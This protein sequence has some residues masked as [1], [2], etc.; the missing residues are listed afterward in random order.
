M[1]QEILCPKCEA[2][3]ERKPGPYHPFYGC[4]NYP[5]CK[6]MRKVYP[7]GLVE[8]LRVDRETRDYQHIAEGRFQRLWLSVDDDLNTKHKALAWLAGQLHIGVECCLFNQMN[9]ETAKRALELCMER[10]KAAQT[11]LTPGPSPEGEGERG[12]NGEN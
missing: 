5:G 3:M 12:P 11:D 10:E 9:L 6:G 7:G 8:G 1:E 4:P 2:E